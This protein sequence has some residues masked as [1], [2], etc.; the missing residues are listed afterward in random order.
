MSHYTV[1]YCRLAGVKHG[2]M[3]FWD[4]KGLYPTEEAPLAFKTFIEK[5]LE[6]WDFDNI[7]AAHTANMIGG[8]KAA[9]TEA[10]ARESPVLCQ[11]SSKFAVKNAAVKG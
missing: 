7:C 10:L 5:I 6:D 11:L 3:K 1:L 2:L 9:L 8:A 4:Y